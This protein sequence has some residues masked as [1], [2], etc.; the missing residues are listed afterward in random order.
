MPTETSVVM[1]SRRIVESY[2][3]SGY[4]YRDEVVSDHASTWS[5]T[6]PTRTRGR[7]PPGWLHPTPYALEVSSHRSLTGDIGWIYGGVEYGTRYQ[8][9]GN[10]VASHLDGNIAPRLLMP[11]GRARAEIKALLDLKDSS[12][13]YGVAF[14]E[15]QRTLGLVA[16]TVNRLANGINTL[17]RTLS[18]RSALKALG[19]RPRTRTTKRDRVDPGS[20]PEA[21]LELKYG[22]EPLL[23]DV[24]GSMKELAGR[25]QDDWVVTAKGRVREEMTYE[26]VLKNDGLPLSA[27]RKVKEFEGHFVRLDGVIDD[28]YHKTL[29][30][31]GL[32]NPFEIAWEM[33]PYSFVVDWFLP[34]GDW[35]STWDA[36][37]G[38][39][40][41]SGS[42]SHLIKREDHRSFGG[43]T[44]QPWYFTHE[45]GNFAGRRRYVKLTREVY[46]GYPKGVTVLP[47]F[48]NPLSVG[49]VANGLSLLATAFGR[50]PRSRAY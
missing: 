29:S 21:W 7:K 28:S 20:I 46:D 41:R 24:H 45:T 25:P 9:V 47:S 5:E 49:H 14:A 32:E 35:I 19:K 34:I 30:R 17:R 23:G 16:G 15:A 18:K 8:Q 4:V 12:V 13:N 42:Y 37:L 22:W 43:P 48:K 6:R 26:E 31:V 27:L 11:N 50:K 40:F 3:Q 1:G 44:K 2:Q 33:L 38:M 36:S 39:E 10:N